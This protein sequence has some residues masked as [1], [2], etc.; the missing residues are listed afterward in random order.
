HLVNTFLLVAAMTL[1]A[2]FASGAPPLAWRRQGRLGWLGLAAMVSMLLVGVS[3][4]VAALGDTLFPAADLGTA[5]AA[6]L[7]PTAH[8]LVRLRVIHPFAAVGL[9][10]LLLA[11]RFVIGTRRPS[12]A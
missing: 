3:G 9:A 8:V 4:A 5:L 6:D 7:S 12:P 1:L 11:T 2:H 10:F